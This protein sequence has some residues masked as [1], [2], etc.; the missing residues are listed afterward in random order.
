MPVTFTR[1]PPSS[2]S[3]D[4][5]ALTQLAL[6]ING[7][8]RAGQILN[9]RGA[10]VSIG[11]DP[12][13]TLRLRAA[14]VLPRHCT[15]FQTSHGPVVRRESQNTWLNGQPFVQAAL[16]Q[17]DRLKVGPIEFEVLA[18]QPILSSENQR[19][20]PTHTPSR[21]SESRAHRRQPDQ[22]NTAAAENE[23]LRQ[24]AE[25]LRQSLLELKQQR[26][27]MHTMSSEPKRDPNLPRQYALGV[28]AHKANETRRGIVD[29]ADATRESIREQEAH[30]DETRSALEN[31]RARLDQLRDE[32][33]SLRSQLE[34]QQDDANKQEAE[35][36]KKRLELDQRLAELRCD[37]M[38]LEQN[39]AELEQRQAETEQQ[40][41]E[42]AEQQDELGREQELQRE[43]I[44]GERQEVEKQCEEIKQQ[45]AAWEKENQTQE[46]SLGD[47]V[48]ALEQ[49]QEI[50]DEQSKDLQIQNNQLE[51]RRNKIAQQQEQLGSQEAE[52][53]NR[54][55]AFA[56]QQKQLASQHKQLA[57]Q[58]KQLANDRDQ[59]D[60]QS[61]DIEGQ[62]AAISADREA[63]A[64]LE[65]KQQDLAAA[66]EALG[67]ERTEFASLRD[68]F[69]SEREEHL[70]ERTALDR[71]RLEFETKREGIVELQNQLNIERQEL[72]AQA[73]QLDALRNELLSQREEVNLDQDSG[74]SVDQAAADAPVDEQYMQ[75]DAAAYD[76]SEFE[77]Q[78]S[79]AEAEPISAGGNQ[80]QG[81]LDATAL[82]ASGVYSY[83]PYPE[84]SY[85]EEPIAESDGP[86]LSQAS[87]APAQDAVVG[88]DGAMDQ[89]SQ[90]ANDNQ[91]FLENLRRSA[92][93]A[94]HDDD[95]A[96]ID[97]DQADGAQSQPE[98]PV[99]Q[100]F[101]VDSVVNP[102]GEPPAADGNGSIDQYMASL[103]QRVSGAN[104]VA[105][106]EPEPEVTESDSTTDVEPEDNLE[107][108]MA[109]RHEAPESNVNMHA[110]RQL[111]NFSAKSAIEHSQQSRHTSAARGKGGIAIF[112]L[113]LSGG[114]FWM[115]SGTQGLGFLSAAVAFIA[116]CLWAVQAALLFNRANHSKRAVKDAAR[117]SGE[118]DV[119]NPPDANE[120]E[121][122]SEDNR[123]AE[124]PEEGTEA[125][126][127]HAESD[128]TA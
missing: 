94:E 33:E 54:Q 64:D 100:H 78:T 63:L 48:S 62:R 75:H 47:R 81:E 2:Q 124:S 61:K 23:Q 97:R 105:F 27:R 85:A 115:S 37:R 111:A 65:L 22:P 68:A 84:E 5:P 99:A 8:D 107:T 17:G 13:C 119:Q 67:D 57:E 45:R 127:E 110:M 102:D 91:E 12:S 69:E 36:D 79:V 35:L 3:P 20:A 90:T 112:A 39:Q 31:D 125:D 96:V 103:L 38:T 9:L 24:E 88:M 73:Q 41:S 53:A 42:L 21:Q 86:A 55:E 117:D 89:N 128:V 16:A 101:A 52:L 87:E 95:V 72:E 43:Q 120:D 51:L 14:H 40:R 10:R 118:I 113:A 121:V 29:D 98:E 30:L 18:Q 7:T 1:T 26:R 76:G 92:L 82:S 80:E 46:K 74:E 122:V 56:S 15:I 108:E 106:D 50:I 93:A 32:L 104:Q 71:E 44:Q 4:K 114:M 58:Q 123:D 83:E 6:R 116:A 19:Q 70:A 66:S 11:S 34:L 60:L 77:S 49:Q 59:L 28:P 25:Q 109:P 126:L